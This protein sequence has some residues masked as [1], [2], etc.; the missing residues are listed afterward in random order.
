MGYTDS[1]LLRVVVCQG[2]L[3]AL[4]GYGVGYVLTRG[5]FWL[6]HDNTGLPM[7]LKREDTLFILG[8]TLLMCT[9]SGILAARK[10]VALDPAELYA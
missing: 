5:A 9:L 10:L 3:L 1:W 4:L 8:L 7:L 2:V 6:I